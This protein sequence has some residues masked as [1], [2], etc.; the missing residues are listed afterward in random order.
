MS[1]QMSEAKRVRI[2]EQRME[3]RINSLLLWAPLLL[4]HFP[5]TFDFILHKLNLCL[6][7][8]LALLIVT[9]LLWNFFSFAGFF[10]KLATRSLCCALSVQKISRQTLQIHYFIREYAREAQLLL[11]HCVAFFIYTLWDFFFIFISFSIHFA[12][13]LGFCLILILKAFGWRRFLSELCTII[14]IEW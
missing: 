1:V 12:R 3:H 13:R 5:F 10:S 8:P 9:F 7:A 6:L 11:Q 14:C 4:L 2:E